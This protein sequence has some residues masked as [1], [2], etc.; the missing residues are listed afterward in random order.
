MGIAYAGS[1]LTSQN[2]SHELVGLGVWALSPIVHDSFESL[3]IRR[4]NGLRDY[5][6]M[7]LGLDRSMH[8]IMLKHG[9]VPCTSRLGLNVRRGSSSHSRHPTSPNALSFTEAH[10][11]SVRRWDNC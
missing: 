10:I 3:P 2:T 4:C 6:E 5:G 8:T 9:A 1:R 7:T 11:A